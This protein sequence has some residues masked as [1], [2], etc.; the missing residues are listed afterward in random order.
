M[1]VGFADHSL[2]RI[3]QGAAGP[4][5]LQ[6]YIS[7]AGGRVD[8]GWAVLVARVEASV[9]P[10]GLSRIDALLGSTEKGSVAQDV[11]RG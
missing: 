8:E 7:V 11:R 3:R 10:I 4:P 9:A 1:K 5:V 2:E 6:S